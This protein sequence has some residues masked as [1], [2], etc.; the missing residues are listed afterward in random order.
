MSR[1]DLLRSLSAPP[2][3]IDADLVD[4]LADASSAL[5][6]LRAA[7]PSGPDASWDRAYSRAQSTYLKALASLQKHRKAHPAPPVAP[8]FAPATIPADLAPF[9]PPGLFTAADN[10][11]FENLD[12]Y[13]P[14]ESSDPDDLPDPVPPPVPSPS[15]LS[16][17]SPPPLNRRDRRRLEAYKRSAA[18]R[19][20]RRAAASLV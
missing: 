16:H 4:Q 20:P 13:D 14:D 8:E 17:P 12:S 5:A 2:E 19:A 10:H 11:L 3:L 15:R 6:R 9:I 1:A 18:A 7:T